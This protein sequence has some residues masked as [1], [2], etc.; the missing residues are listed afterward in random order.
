V[1]SNFKNPARVVYFTRS[2]SQNPTRRAG[3]SPVKQ[4]FGNVS[5]FKRVS[6]PKRMTM[7]QQV[8]AASST[9]GAAMKPGWT[10]LGTG[11]FY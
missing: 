8:R 2:I 6:S 7:C 3:Q 1:I 11:W 9:A 4:G 10:L 5:L